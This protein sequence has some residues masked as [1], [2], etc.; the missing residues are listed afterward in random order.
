M[1]KLR[2]TFL[3]LFVANVAIKHYTVNSTTINPTPQDTV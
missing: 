2:E 3:L 1:T